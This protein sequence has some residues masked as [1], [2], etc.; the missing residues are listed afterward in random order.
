LN[1]SRFELD[2]GLRTVVASYEGTKAVTIEVAVA[3]GFGY[4]TGSNRGVS[5]LVEHMIFRGSKS[6]DSIVDISAYVESLGGYVNASTDRDVTTY[7]TYTPVEGFAQACEV[8]GDILQNPK[9]AEA[10]C[11]LE[12]QI[13]VDELRIA[14]DTP[15]DWASQ[16]LDYLLW[17]NHGLGVPVSTDIENIEGLLPLHL[18][19]HMNDVYVA[20]NMVVGIAG[21]IDTS[22]ARSVVQK[23]FGGIPSGAPTVWPAV[24]RNIG[25]NLFCEDRNVMQTSFVIGAGTLGNEDPDKYVLEILNAVLGDGMGSRLFTNIREKRG[26]AYDIYS[27][28]YQYRDTGALTISATVSPEV[29]LETIDATIEQCHALSM[30]P[31]TDHELRRAFEYVKGGLVLSMEHSSNVASW[32]TR[33]ELLENYKMTVDE[34]VHKLA[35]VGKRDVALAAD[36]LFRS[37]KLCLSVV[38]PNPPEAQ[39]SNLLSRRTKGAMNA[40]I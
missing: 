16:N 11:N 4:E 36:K 28:L 7:F 13:I 38:G 18:R 26:L 30:D 20:S 29:A 6:R 5:H 8:L 25:S 31:P 19:R 12:K 35:E 37:E 17:P 9:F 2:N 15:E 22:H 27:G 33:E 34:V 40:S 24:D 21:D 3:T 32:H 10:D 23:A 1:I 14:R 39:L